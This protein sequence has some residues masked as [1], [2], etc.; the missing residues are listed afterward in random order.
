MIRKIVV[1]HELGDALK[2]Q[3][4]LANVMG[5]SVGVQNAVYNKEQ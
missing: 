1:S 4:E 2:K 5:H 3:K